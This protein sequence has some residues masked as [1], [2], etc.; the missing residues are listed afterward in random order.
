MEWISVKDRL[1]SE[2]QR[3]DTFGVDGARLVDCE[4]YDGCFWDL[5]QSFDTDD[6]GYGCSFYTHLLEGVTHWMPLPEPP[7]ESE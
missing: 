1:P 7:K 4:F 5:E 6:C 2:H 3:I